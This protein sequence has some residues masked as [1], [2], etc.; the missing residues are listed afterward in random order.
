[1]KPQIRRHGW[2]MEPDRL[3]TLLSMRCAGSHVHAP[4][5][6]DAVP[7]LDWVIPRGRTSVLAHSAGAPS[8]VNPAQ[9]VVRARGMLLWSEGRTGVSTHERVVPTSTLGLG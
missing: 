3:V 9:V 1:M 2:V 5:P 6:R 8:M 7:R 4:D